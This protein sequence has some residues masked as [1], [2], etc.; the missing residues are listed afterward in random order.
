MKTIVKIE[1]MTCQG[2]ANSVQEIISSIANVQSVDVN[3]E[4]GT[5]EIQSA[6]EISVSELQNAIEENNK[7]YEVQG[8]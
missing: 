2:C 8:I 1:G 4:K 6:K 5:A 3:L 7:D